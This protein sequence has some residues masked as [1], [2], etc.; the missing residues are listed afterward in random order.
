MNK[1][2]GLGII[3]LAAGAD[4]LAI[5]NDFDSRL[6]VV[7]LCDSNAAAARAT[8]ER[9][10]IPFVT[11]DP[12]DLV[13]QPGIDAV[14]VCGS[15]AERY[16]HCMAALSAGKRVLSGSPM[17]GSLPDSLELARE[18][19]RA[20]GLLMAAAPYRWDRELTAI[21][22]LAENGDLGEIQMLEAR[23]ALPPK[24]NPTAW[25]LAVSF[26]LLRWTAGDII[27]VYAL[28]GSSAV[29]ALVTFENGAVGR[30]LALNVHPGFPGRRVSLSVSGSGGA[31]AEGRVV[32]NRLAGL[33]AMTF[34]AQGSGDDG[35]LGSVR[36]FEK[37][38]DGMLSPALDPWDSVRTAAVCAAVEESLRTGLPAAV[39][40]VT[41]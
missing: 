14:A 9:H 27:S 36:E 19:D 22:S 2:I 4:L 3:G 26:D 30:A 33:P 40:I 41:K 21:H 7:A 12:I 31:V 20:G 23:H 5:N 6:R 37:S 32:L 24:S 28:S 16:S 38:L 13:S 1:D 15:I 34:A 17:A 10:H 25:D 35:M 11:T 8:A 39:A 29:T 18:S